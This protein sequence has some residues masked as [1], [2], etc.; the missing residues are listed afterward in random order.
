MARELRRATKED[1]PAILAF[2]NA[3]APPR[4]KMPI[5]IL[6]ESLFA[7]SH[8]HGENTA[9]CFDG[10]A[11]RGVCGWVR[12]EQGEFFGA[13]VFCA[14]G[15]SGAM[16]LERLLEEAKGSRWIRVSCFPEESFKREA[17]VARGLRPEFEFVEFEIVPKDT[18]LPEVSEGISEQPLRSASPGE[19]RELMN[20]SF[21]GVDNSLPV[22]KS[23]AQE[24]IEGKDKDP[25][26]SLVWRDS[27]GR[28]VAFVITDEF[29]Y[30][31]SIGVHPAAQGRG[32]GSLLY[33][34]VLALA[35]RTGKKRLFTTVSSRNAGSLALHRRL[36]IP[37]VERRTVYQRTFP[38]G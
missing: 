1:L 28:L 29:G 37:E 36:G 27:S 13:P 15:A 14:D 24:L 25:A 23:D 22:S 12:G 7:F 17:L 20:L 11:L 38:H 4:R 2:Q 5:G 32:Y 34:R 9:L 31:D 21:A 26:L 30:V 10:G 8:R 19:F 33:R 18:A 3:I 6:E 35:A 16:I